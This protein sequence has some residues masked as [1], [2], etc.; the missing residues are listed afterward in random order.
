MSF[1]TSAARG[2]VKLGFICAVALLLPV[3]SFAQTSKG[4][5]AGTVVDSSGAVVVNANVTA[6]NV[7]TGTERTT[8]SGPNGGYRMEAV[9]PG[10]YRVTVTANG[11][12][13]TT[14]E[15][16]D[17]KASIITSV[18]AELA[19]GTVSDTVEV[20]GAAT[21]LQTQSGS[22]EHTIE[23]VET[24]H[25]P[26]FNLN[27]ISLA[28]TQ[29]GVIDVGSNSLSN[30]TGFS[31]NGSRPRANN[32][33]L[34]G[35]DDNDNSIQGQALQPNNVNTVQEV[36]VLTNSYSAE[37]GRGGGSV[38]NVIT[39]GGTNQFHGSAWELYAG[40]GLNAVTAQDGFGGQT[41]RTKPRFDTHTFG[42][43]AGG[44]IWK[45]K[46]FAFGS[47]QWQRFYGNAAPATILAPT[48]NGV[49]ALTAAN[50][51]NANLLLQYF[52][53]LRGGQ[54]SLSS[55][56]IGPRAGCPAAFV[57]ATSGGCLVEFGST[58][59]TPPAQL[60]P[61]TQWTYRID[62]V[63]RAADTISARY[64]HDRN[65]LSP[66][67]FNFPQSLPGLDTEQGGPSENFGITWTH[68]LSASAVNEFRASE[69]RFDFQFAPTAQTLKNPLFNLPT[70]NS[71]SGLNANLFPLL[72]VNS[73]LPQGRGHTTYQFQDAYTLVKGIETFKVGGDVARILVR[74]EVP[75]NSR[76]TLTFGSGGGF[77]GLGNFVD[78]FTGSSNGAALT[79]G[80][81]TIRPKVFQEGFYFQDTIHAKSNLTVDLGLRYEF[82]NNPANVL[83]YPGINIQTEPSNTFPPTPVHVREDGNNFGPRVGFSYTPRFWNGLFGQDKTVL[84]AGYGVFYDTLFTNITDNEAASSPNAVSG[85]LLGDSDPNSRGLAN[86]TGLLGQ[87]S[88]NLTLASSVSSI[89]QNLKNPVTHQWNANIERELPLSMVFTAA[90]VGNRGERL[91][92]NDELNPG[93]GIGLPRLNPNRGPITV[94]DNS[95]DSIYHSL[96]LKVDRRFK[97]GVLIRGAYTY[98][99]LIDNVSEVFTLFG[100]AT[101]FPQNEL[102]TS[103][104]RSQDR[105][106]S[107]YDRRHRLA[108]TYVWDI[109][110]WNSSSNFLT[111]A[112]SFLTRGWEI[113][114]TSFFQTGAPATI[115]SGFDQNGDRRAT[116]DRPFLGNA[117]AP[118]SSFGIDGSF[119]AKQGGVA[120]TI[121]DG[122]T[123][124]A[125][126]TLTAVAAN[127]VHFLVLPGLG[128]VGRNTFLQ[129]GAINN[130][131]AFS[132]RFHIPGK[133]SQQLEF[134]SEFYNIFNHPNEGL[135]DS[136]SN[137]A[138]TDTVLADGSS[139]ADNSLTRYG[140][141]QIKLQLRYSF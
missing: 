28:L 57:S 96:D 129:P 130:N 102:I 88:P 140:G 124:E 119:L 120:G 107:A 8:T 137:T 7:Q 114:G 51:P 12:K 77:S 132:R 68:T 116:N 93:L 74:D 123:F 108:L 56:D 70:V 113:A 45:N 27:V 122:Q 109:H 101:S 2:L 87:I 89:D 32:F 69:G 13:T 72:G 131:M 16:V 14:I 135:G 35:Q 90:Y 33:L 106:L 76:G 136:V 23:S 117:S 83:P 46:L 105:G 53:S 61:D 29:P 80:N 139:F 9:E 99:K 30:G 47:S 111:S 43:T 54:N 52:G 37:F 40:S 97:S 39:K 103:N 112:V 1:T 86:A 125:D 138:G 81:P 18:N 62:F 71:I 141:R 134:R 41:S 126:G 92:A 22:L 73:A 26:V 84:R 63:P 100:S 49:A 115:N 58:Q 133:E 82:D 5:V 21:D 91:F 38:T 64:I 10:L 11:F 3:F 67:F 65:S 48:A 4:I 6:R 118:F 121:Y 34:D 98:S 50:T 19:V 94:R 24:E 59:R 95:G 55:V 79:F 110:G 128:N 31:V 20:S 104:G 25:V 15:Q 36:V 42:F 60:N 85:T 44:P 75:F 78:N 127:S 66:D 17:V